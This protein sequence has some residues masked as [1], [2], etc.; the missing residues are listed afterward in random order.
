MFHEITHAGGVNS[1][2]H[3]NSRLGK[4]AATTLPYGVLYAIGVVLIA[5]T[6]HNPASTQGTWDYFIPLVGLVA[7][8]SGWSH[9]A[10]DIWQTRARYILRQVVHWAAVLLVIHLLFQSNVQHFLKAETDGFVIIYILGLAGILSGLYLDWK[11]ALFGLFL[12]FSGVIIAFLDN[13]A[14]LIAVGAAATIAVIVTAF[15]WIRHQQR[16]ESQAGSAP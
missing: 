3:P 5:M 6:D 8:F 4:L 15:V 2:P 12:I 9:H 1:L 11:M 7:T 13:N 10:G 14:L 16:R